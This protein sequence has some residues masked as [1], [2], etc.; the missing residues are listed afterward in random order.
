[1]VLHWQ[2]WSFPRNVRVHKK[3]LLVVARVESKNSDTKK[4]LVSV[5]HKQ[6]KESLLHMRIRYNRSGK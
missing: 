2:N 1:M 3:I 5:W 6:T 4:K